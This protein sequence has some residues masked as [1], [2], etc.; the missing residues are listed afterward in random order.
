MKP[1][2]IVTVAMSDEFIRHLGINCTAKGMLKENDKKRTAMECL[3]L[4][5]YLKVTNA[6]D[7]QIED[8]LPEDWYGEIGTVEEREVS[9]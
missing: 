5:T 9:K 6:P 1:F 8:L 3:G 2:K 7:E 4:I